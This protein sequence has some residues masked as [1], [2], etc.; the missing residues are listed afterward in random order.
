MENEKIEIKRIF[1]ETT[2]T[3]KM[4]AFIGQQ[5]RKIN[6][7]LKTEKK[8]GETAGEKNREKRPWLLFGMI[9]LVILLTLGGS[10]FYFY[11]QYKKVLIEK[12]SAAGE[13]SPAKS[14]LQALKEEIGKIYELPQDEEPILATVTDIE[15]VKV[16]QFFA[17]AQNGDKVLIYTNNKKAVLYRPSS[18]KLIEVSPVS[19]I[20]ESTAPENII[21]P[22]QNPES[23]N[24]ENVPAENV[25]NETQP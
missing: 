19:G 3:R 6:P 12:N 24:P 22:V 18:K 4:D 25:P 9:I 16:Q 15:K 5:P 1:P 11:R 23:Q 14:E 17:K 7:S 13:Q 2:A 20:D 8:E 10:S 21:A